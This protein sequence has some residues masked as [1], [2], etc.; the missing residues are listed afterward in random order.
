MHVIVNVN[1]AIQQR[2]IH[3]II[4]LGNIFI[5]DLC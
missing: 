4:V 3:I 5:R 1:N 2:I